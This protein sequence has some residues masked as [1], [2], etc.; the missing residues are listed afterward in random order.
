MLIKMT[1]TMIAIMYM[2]ISYAVPTKGFMKQPTIKPSR[3]K[4]DYPKVM[5]HENIKHLSMPRRNLCQ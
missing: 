2:E 3:Y 1:K 4:V 5:F